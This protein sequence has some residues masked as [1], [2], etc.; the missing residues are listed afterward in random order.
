[1]EAWTQAWRKAVVRAQ[2]PVARGTQLTE[3]ELPDDLPFPF[4]PGH[5]VSLRMETP[6]GMVRHPYTVCGANPE[7]RRLVFVYRVIP[8]GRLT[9]A[10]ATLA[11]GA[12]V[13]VAGLHHEPIR[14]EV[15][16]TA[17]RIVGLATSSGLGPL[18]GYAAQ[19][20]T[21][22]ER[23]PLHLAVG[24]RN[25]E[26]L[27]LEAELEA[28]GRIHP[29]FSWSPVLSRPGA[30]WSGLRGRLTAHAGELVPLPVES[31]VHAVGNMAMIRTFEAAWNLAGLPDRRFSSEGF[32]NWNAEADETAARAIADCF[33]L[34]RGSALSRPSR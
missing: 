7:S 4:E 2:R 1:M 29:N 21:A 8:D 32:F 6:Q 12:E 23:R 33:L 13:E 20:L 17:G 24:V 18:W 27:P 25:A 28:L 26:D 9:P 19:A 16:P 11:A 31:H 15:D 5:V 14:L 22:G 3:V 34:N 10:F 30:D